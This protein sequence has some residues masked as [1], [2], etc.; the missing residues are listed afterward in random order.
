MNEPT[1]VEETVVAI[2]A[3]AD[4]INMNGIDLVYFKIVQAIKGMRVPSNQL[5]LDPRSN[6]MTALITLEAALIAATAKTKGIERSEAK[7]IEDVIRRQIAKLVGSGA[8]SAIFF[9]ALR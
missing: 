4:D 5:R 3:L 7:H 2:R 8:I 9:N 6:L 1:S